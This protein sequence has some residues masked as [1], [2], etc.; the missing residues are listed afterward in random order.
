MIDTTAS[1]IIPFT[2]KI[3]A[4]LCCMGIFGWAAAAQAELTWESRE[5]FQKAGAADKAVGA[6][7]KFTNSGKAPVVI[8]DVRSSCGCTTASLPKK[9]YAAGESGQVEALF[10]IGNRRGLQ[11]K[12]IEVMIAGQE[13]PVVLTIKTLVPQVLDIKPS[14]VFWKQDSA[15]TAIPVKMTVGV[16][17]PVAI[18]GVSSDNPRMQARLEV[19]IPGKS[20]Q[21]HISPLT[22]AELLTAIITIKIDFPAQTPRSFTIEAHVK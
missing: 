2:M 17:E 6:V 21:L 19:L 18:V 4:W 9:N 22:T 12:T 20:Y 14:F 8:T 1:P 11:V 10:M 5:I 15:T 13:E 16:D 7:F 3:T